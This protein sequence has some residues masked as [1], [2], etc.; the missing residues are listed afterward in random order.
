MK[1]LLIVILALSMSLLRA[2]TSEVSSPDKNIVI[3][4]STA[5]NQLTYAVSFKGKPVLLES[6]LAMEFGQSAP[7]GKNMQIL[8]SDKRTVDETWKPVTA[9]HSQIRNNYNEMTVTLKETVAPGRTYSIVFKAFNDGIG[10]RYAFDKEGMKQQDLSIRYE[11]TTYHFPGD[12]KAWMAD[13]RKY[14]NDN[15]EEYWPKKLSSITDKNLIAKPML[16]KMGDSLYAAFT[17]ADVRDYPNSFFSPAEKTDKGILLHTKQAPLPNEDELG[18]KAY[19][20]LPFATPWRV[21]M[22]GTHPGRFIESE[23]VMNLAEPNKL[24]DVSWIKP[25]MCAWDNWW[26]C[27]V[28]MDT[29]TNKKFIQFASEMGFPYQ[30]IDWKWYGEFNRPEADITKVTP[31]LDMP[32]VLAFAKEKNVKCWLWLYYDDAIRMYEQAFPLYEKWGVVG[33]KVDFWRREDQ[34]MMRNYEKMTKKA[35][36]C[37]LMINFHSACINTGLERTYPN[38]MTREGIMGDE[39]NGWST[40][41]T[42]EH[43]TT[44]PFTRMLAGPMDYTP[45]GFHNGGIDQFKNQ[46]P[47]IVMN[48]RAAELAKF[49][50]FFSPI[51]T[52]ADHPDFY[53][54]Q[55]GLDFL[56]I[57]PADMDEMKV[58]QGAP[59]EYIVTARRKGNNWFIGA[60]TNSEPREVEVDLSF[61]GKTNFKTTIYADAVDADV[62][63]EKLNITTAKYSGKDKIKIKMVKAGGWAASLISEK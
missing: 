41:V 63:P 5:N 59:G 37:H 39:Y 43:N 58:L 62:N 8:K 14:T 38:I 9:K 20:K 16:V 1:K 29:E 49:V 34:E 45:G 26:C 21:V 35:A 36:E 19:V 12:F 30:L 52:V 15:E 47:T 55:P 53:K 48:T 24:Q 57:V 7:I 2:Q 6:P 25:G 11:K 3:T 23:I 27:D 46:K 22:I 61:L 54:G 40:R 33:I 60:M 17:E 56:K 32:G 10:F 13:V 44:I 18:M 51:T 42:P 28:K 4:L 31:A 50:I